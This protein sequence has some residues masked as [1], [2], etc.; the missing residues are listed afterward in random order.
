MALVVKNLPTDAGDARD[1]VLML[2][3]EDPLEKEMALHPVFL[4]GKLHGR[5]A[6]W[7]SV[8]G[9]VKNWTEVYVC[10]CTHTHTHRYVQQ[11]KWTPRTLCLVKKVRF[12]P[13]Q[14]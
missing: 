9:A 7:A 10:A 13:P 8:H 1:R 5:G 11:T 12:S 3:R 14:Y 6:S 4:H 2:G